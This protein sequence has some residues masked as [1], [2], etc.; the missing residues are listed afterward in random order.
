M[1]TSAVVENGQFFP[2][3]F[4]PSL[5]Y[6]KL[7]CCLKLPF[8]SQWLSTPDFFSS[9]FPWCPNAMSKQWFSYINT[10][11]LVRWIL[12]FKGFPKAHLCNV[13]MNNQ[14]RSLLLGSCGVCLGFLNMG[15]HWRLQLPDLNSRY[16]GRWD[17]YGFWW[18]TI[19]PKRLVSQSKE[20]ICV[21]VCHTGSLSLV[22]I[23][24]VFQ[25][26]CAFT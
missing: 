1:Q 4:S 10:I 17:F 20:P 3:S 18:P 16:G 22:I 8:S 21:P 7:Y 13:W 26:T 23:F 11:L 6:S 14:L 24:A 19:G 25:Y 2:L 9:R 12:F 15:I 5:L